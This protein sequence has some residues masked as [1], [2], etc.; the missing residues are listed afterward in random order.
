MIP[1]KIKIS[2]IANREPL[3]PEYEGAEEVQF[4]AFGVIEGG[5]VSGKTSVCFIFEA[6]DGRTFIAQSSAAIMEN[7]AA[8]LVGAEN[9]FA[10]RAQDN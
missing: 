7:M 2:E 10:N 3:F 5:M 1:L 9:R 6:D 8:A 4:K